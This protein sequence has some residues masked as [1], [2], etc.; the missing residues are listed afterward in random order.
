MKLKRRSKLGRL[1]RFP[2][3][4]LMHLEHFGWRTSWQLTSQLFDDPGKPK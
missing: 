4:F 1:I 2:F 3:V